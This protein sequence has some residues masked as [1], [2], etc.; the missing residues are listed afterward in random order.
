MDGHSIESLAKIAAE[1]M[2][3]AMSEE[4]TEEAAEEEAEVPAATEPEP[5]SLQAEAHDVAVPTDA[6]TELARMKALMSAYLPADLN[7]EDELKAV[8]GTPE[9]GYGYRKPEVTPQ[10]TQTG[11][12]IQA[13][14]KESAPPSN[15]TRIRA[16]GQ[17]GYITIGAE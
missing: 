3:S 10:T 9:D 16:A 2:L 4:P 11:R 5:S 12:R 15:G 1:A 7:I 13:P 14:A 8:Y 17:P 6:E